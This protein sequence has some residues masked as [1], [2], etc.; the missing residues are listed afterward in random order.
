MEPA[1]RLQFVCGALAL[2]LVLMNVVITFLWLSRS[3]PPKLLPESEVLG[4][5]ASAL[6]LLVAAPSVKRAILKRTEAEFEGDRERWIAAWIHGTFIAFVL[7]EGAGLLG[8]VLALLSGNP[9]WS[10]ATGAA[11]LLAMFVDRPRG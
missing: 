7:R 10:W 2:S 1:R 8:F 9:W 11:A 6:I 5:F 3:L 4:M